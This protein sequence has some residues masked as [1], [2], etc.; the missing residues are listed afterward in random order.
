MATVTEE[1][2]PRKGVKLSIVRHV[3]QV[4][5]LLVFCL[6]VVVAGWSL[7][8]ANGGAA[9][10]S[11]DAVATPAQLP[12]FGTLSSSDVGPVTVLDPF[13][14]LQA[15]AASKAFSPD[16]LIGVLPV[17]LVY[18]LIRGRVF[19]G[20]VCPVN[21]VLEAVDWVRRKVRPGSQL[22]ER[23]VPRHVKL[24][25]A[26]AVLVLSA[27]VSVPVFEVVSP[28]SFLNKG[29]LLGSTVGGCTLL[30]IVVAELFW[31]HR[32]WCRALCPLGGFYQ[33]LGK[34]GLVNVKADHGKCIGCDKCKKACL[35]DP[36]ILDDVVAGAAPA[37]CAGDCMLCGK[38]VD[39]CPTGCLTVGV[40]R[41]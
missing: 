41:K 6:P 30:A 35:C 21:L 15:V 10:L 3:V 5:A 19:C 4:L 26:A 32:V 36:V 33:A 17:L 14:M 37:V 13:A 20:W 31:G 24:Y 40:G 28:V 12:F 8:G 22:P 1:K 7:F 9:E 23:V 2:E 27:V 34:V 16:W 11:D 25:V 29:L 38:C 18:G 39:A